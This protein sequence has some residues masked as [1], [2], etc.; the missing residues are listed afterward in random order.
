VPVAWLAE[1]GSV[2]LVRARDGQHLELGT[3][4]VLINPGSVGQP[5]D[6]RPEAS[7][8][9]LDPESG[10]VTWHRVAYDIGAVQRAMR[11]AGLP[12]SLV[13]RLAVGQ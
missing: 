9:I 7:Y 13:A 2:E 4:P 12:A 5:R 3:R 6:G 1:D 10:S 11:A 8:A